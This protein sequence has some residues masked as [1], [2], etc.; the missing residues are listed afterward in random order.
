MESYS[1]SRLIKKLLVCRC[2][3]CD[4]VDVPLEV[5]YVRKVKDLSGK[6]FWERVM[7]ERKRKIF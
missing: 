7:V 2:E 4:A 6:K 3:F 1:R 5:H